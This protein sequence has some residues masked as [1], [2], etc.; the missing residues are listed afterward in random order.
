MEAVLIKRFIVEFGY[1]VDLHGQDVNKAAQKAVKDAISHSCLCGLT[2]ILGV[3]LNEIVVE[4]TVAVS[5]PEEIEEEGIKA[6]LP[7]GEKYVKAI[8]GGMRV[9]GIKEPEF[10]DKD[11]T[12]EVAVACI[13]VNIK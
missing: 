10:G 8:I 5:R 4:A 7:I 13:T 12:I 2:E 9:A 6:V 11:D 3:D 1:G